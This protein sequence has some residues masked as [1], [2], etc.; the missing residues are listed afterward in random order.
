MFEIIG[1]VLCVYWA[2]VAVTLI[3]LNT[4]YSTWKNEFGF[5]FNFFMA[6]LWFI[7]I[8]ALLYE[9]IINSKNK[10]GK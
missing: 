3:V 7:F 6:S 2:I 5:I 4:V 8:P 10:K 1:M 9:E